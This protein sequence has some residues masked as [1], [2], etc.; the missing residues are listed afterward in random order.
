MKKHKQK[1]LPIN[2]PLP[3]KVTQINGTLFVTLRTLDELESFWL[4]HQNLFKYACEGKAVNKNIFLNP[5]EWVFGTSKAAVVETA[6]RWDLVGIRCS[7]YNWAVN[8][9]VEYSYFFMDRENYRTD[10]I[11]K[12]SWTEV[13]ETEYQTDIIERTP[14]NYVGYWTLENLPNDID[15]LYWFSTKS[16]EIR[17]PNIP[18]NSIRKI[19]Q[20]LTFDD[21]KDSDVEEVEFHDGQ[22]IEETITYWRAEQAAG[23][24]YY[25]DENETLLVVRHPDGSFSVR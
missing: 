13:N 25:G 4:E 8:D 19:M 21:W 11:E 12:G 20:E 23:Q 17:D 24:S 1:I 10:M 16:I 6:M 9:P 2:I 15:P 22:S 5:Y 7:F 18:L 14:N 3:E